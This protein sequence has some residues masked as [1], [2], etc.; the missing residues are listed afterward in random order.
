M[1][2]KVLRDPVA[3][4]SRAAE[5]IADAARSAVELR[6]KFTLALSGGSTPW[7]MLGRLAEQSRPW[8]NIEIFQVDER[9]AP[10]GSDL[11]NL[12]HIQKAVEGVCPI[13]MHPMQVTSPDLQ[14][15]AEQYGRLLQQI[16]GIP[17]IIDLVH[18]GLGPDGHTAS[19]VPGDTVLDVTDRDVAVTR[20]YKGSRRMTLTFPAINR[21]RQILWVVTGAEKASALRQLRSADHSIPAG[22]I[23]QT[24]SL[25][26]ADCAAAGEDY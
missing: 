19:L 10:D 15:A 14:K 3:V 6:G 13:R 22:R 1:K 4:A 8:E 11:R 16:V 24:Q 2:L 5:A 7:M 12:T 23:S 26:I 25:L 18:L 9:V 21:C 17:P 20:L